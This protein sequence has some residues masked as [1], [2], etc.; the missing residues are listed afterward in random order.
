VLYRQL[1]RQESLEV[2]D[3]RSASRQ[4]HQLLI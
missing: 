2:S 3:P 4:L 1:S